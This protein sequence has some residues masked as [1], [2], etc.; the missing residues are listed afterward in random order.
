MDKKEIL[1]IVGMIVIVI[2]I[3]FILHFIKNFIIISSIQDKVA[4]YKESTNVHN[5][6]TMIK[7]DQE[8]YSDVYIK[9][10]ES[11]TTF[12][13]I[14]KN[15]NDHK[16]V[17]V[18]HLDER[19]NY[20]ETKDSKT[21]KIY[22]EDYSNSGMQINTY[23]GMTF[24]GKI[25]DSILF[26]INTEIIDGKEYYVI[27]GKTDSMLYDQNAIEAKMYI[28]KDTGLLSTM[29]EKVKVNEEIKEYTYTYKYEFDVVKDED[30]AGPDLSE[31]TIQES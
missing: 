23:Y 21:V 11:K 4:K 17:Q 31:Y 25:R 6:V 22:K 26:I 30:I 20:V 28:E 10:K 27:N 15:G 3:I 2:L 1:K 8:E 13:H 24:D 18:I 19:R 5:I 9:G 12:I 29:V 7:E 16:M 14:D